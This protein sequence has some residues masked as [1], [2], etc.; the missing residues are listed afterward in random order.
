[1]TTLDLKEP[2]RVPIFEGTIDNIAIAKEFGGKTSIQGLRK[3]MRAISRI[4]GWRSL[5]AGFM[6][7]G[8]V[9]KMGTDRLYAF[10]KKVGIDID[11][12]NT[13]R[14]TRIQIL[15]IKPL[16]AGRV[17]PEIGLNFCFNNIKDNDF[18]ACGFGCMQDADYDCQ[19]VERILAKSKK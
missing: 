9:Y 10:N 4:P 16:A 1:M 8:F 12:I 3:A 18:V 13:I 6:K 11:M 17:E 19:L 2:D 15:N 5:Y 14:N 7:S